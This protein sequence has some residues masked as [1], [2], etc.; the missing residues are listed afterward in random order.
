MEQGHI[1]QQKLDQ[2]GKKTYQEL[3]TNRMRGG[4]TTVEETSRIEGGETMVGETSTCYI[5]V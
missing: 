3:E 4:K 2:D 5:R 1:W